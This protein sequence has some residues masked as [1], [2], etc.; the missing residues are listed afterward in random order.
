MEGHGLEHV[1]G[2]G[3]SPFG[4]ESTRRT[5]RAYRAIRWARTCIWLALAGATAALLAK[6]SAA[7]G[8]KVLAGVLYGLTLLALIADSIV[9]RRLRRHG[10][11][12][13]ALAARQRRLTPLPPSR[14][15]EAYVVT[16]RSWRR[17]RRGA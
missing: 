17:A 7:P 3:V 1:P 10:E 6:D 14:P 9:V 13:E 5:W 4:D 16:L 2:V 8:W 15:D 12:T 11:W